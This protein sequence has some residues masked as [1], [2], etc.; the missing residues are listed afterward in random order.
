[1]SSHLIITSTSSLKMTMT[2]RQSTTTRA[3]VR[4]TGF[5]T[6]QC[7]LV[8]PAPKITDAGEYTI[9]VQEP[10][11]PKRKQKKPKG[12]PRRAQ[13]GLKVSVSVKITG[14]NQPRVEVH[15]VILKE[16]ELA[17]LA[18]YTRNQDCPGKR[19]SITWEGLSGR[20]EDKEVSSEIKFMPT[21]RDNGRQVTCR[22][23]Y[24]GGIVTSRNVTLTVQ[25]THPTLEITGQVVPKPVISLTPERVQEGDALTLSCILDSRRPGNISLHRLGETQPLKH[26]IATQLSLTLPSVSRKDSGEYSCLSQQGQATEKSSVQVLVMY[27]P[28]I[29]D[30]TV[31]VKRDGALLCL[32]F[33]QG[34]PP[35]TIEWRGLRVDSDLLEVTNAVWNDTAISTV[36]LRNDSGQA[37][38]C[39]SRNHIGKD[40]RLLQAGSGETHIETCGICHLWV[41]V[42]F[43][44]NVPIIFV[45]FCI[46]AIH[47]RVTV[48]GGVCL[49]IPCTFTPP[50][51]TA[52][53]RL[54]GTWE[55]DGH[56]VS[57]HHHFDI[58]S[59]DDYDYSSEYDNTARVMWTGFTTGQCSLVIP[60][61][62]ITDAGEYTITV[63][64]PKEPKRKQKKPKGGPR[65][66]Q[67]GL[68]VSVSVKITGLNQPR[69]EV[70]PVILKEDELAMLA[71]YTRNQDCPGKR[72]SIT[73]E[74]LSGRKED[75]EV[76]SEIK[77]M[78]TRR[79]D[80]RQVTCRVEYS[81]GIV[82]SQT[83]T[84]TVQYGPE[85]TN[86][87]G[88][89]KRDGVLLC[90][91]FSRGVPPP[92]IEWRG[93]R[94]DS[95]LLEVTNG[96]W[97]D[98]AESTVALRNDSGQAV[99]CVSRNHIGEDSR[100]LQAGT[101]ETLI[102]TCGI[103]HLWVI[104]G[105]FLN[106]PIIFVLFYIY[107][108]HK[109][110]TGKKQ[111]ETELNDTYTT[112]DNTTMSPDY[113][114][115]RRATEN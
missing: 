96:V 57:S 93:L 85:I 38:T 43:F 56:V 81:G 13:T 76:S 11:E 25:Y 16:D 15:P 68:K 101:G 98:T 77:F 61:P 65:H 105:F 73:W 99:T 74:G 70:H 67:T 71:C 79:D 63:Q 64:E 19:P 14:L 66:A 9:T 54:S 89:M 3:R 17:T 108:I 53:Q 45:L 114:I 24:S 107:A 109:R 92:T 32:C 52:F 4:W 90:L 95:D 69:V 104:V 83:V 29:T 8:I 82:T 59:E 88:C 42:G 60:A 110:L 78:P 10:K 75:Q 33:S 100:L 86:G 40:S 106:V 47:K 91:C 111:Q 1:M 2:T 80:G 87:T 102:E 35:P 62:K 72:P 115:I 51:G 12:G 41:I 112:L 30:E 36:A 55:K 37:V 58:F 28:E 20:K 6:G 103:C 34:V 49:H 113:D 22:V 46:Y 94:V 7:S 44:L 27:G 31:C 48:D 39:V 21:R 23:E 97:N 26:G 5:T 18:C 50:Q 84:L